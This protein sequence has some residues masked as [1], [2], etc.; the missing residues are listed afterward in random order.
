MDLEY[1]DE[2]AATQFYLEEDV[3]IIQDSTMIK[4]ATPVMDGEMA[5]EGQMHQATDP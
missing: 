1:G 3:G 4:I 2:K 5:Q